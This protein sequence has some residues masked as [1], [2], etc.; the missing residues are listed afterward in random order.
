MTYLQIQGEIKSLKTN[1]DKKVICL[2]VPSLHSGGMER[3]MSELANELSGKQ[4]LTIHLI[5]L[6]NQPKFYKLADNV[7]IHEPP[8]INKGANKILLSIRLLKYLRGLLKKINPHSFLSF[9]AKYNS[10]VMLASSGLKMNKFLSDRNSP[11]INSRLTFK[12]HSVYKTGSGFQ[13]ILKHIMYPGATGIIVQTETAKKIEAERL[14]HPNI[15]SIPNPIRKLSPNEEQKEK[16]I[17][18]VGRFVATKQQELLIEIFSKIDHKDWKLVFA[19][20]GPLL[21]NAKKLVSE[22]NLENSVEFAGNR[23]DIDKLYHKSEIFAFTSVSEGFPNAL[24]EALSTPLATIAI[25]CIAGPSDLIEDGYNGFLIAQN[26]NEE[27]RKKL[28][29]LMNDSEL[30][31]KLKLNSIEKMK[32]FNFETI[33]NT[34]YKVLTA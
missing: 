11:Q 29:M 30:R 4:D 28:S 10:F 12:K 21:E 6:S 22:L 8:F 1:S 33:V 23:T 5:I 9:G 14:R 2:I 13:Y 31:E 19:G 32:N 15:I 17:L 20:E 7:I 26:D 27:Y 24:A 18:N 3:V 16:I 25:D 34:Y